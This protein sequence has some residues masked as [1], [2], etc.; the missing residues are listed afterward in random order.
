MEAD[1]ITTGKSNE[2]VE[3]EKLGVAGWA[4]KYVRNLAELEA[5]AASRVRQVRGASATAGSV[6]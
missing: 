3:R 1:T 6:E 5:Q 4:E 2:V